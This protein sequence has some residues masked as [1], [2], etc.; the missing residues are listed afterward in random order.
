M[1]TIFNRFQEDNVQDMLDEVARQHRE[2]RINKEGEEWSGGGFLKTD[3]IEINSIKYKGFPL[4]I[5]TE[6]DLHSDFKKAPLIKGKKKFE[7]HPIHEPAYLNGFILKEFWDDYGEE[8]ILFLKQND[9]I[10]ETDPL[11]YDLDIFAKDNNIPIPP[12]GAV[13][14]DK[15]YKPYERLKRHMVTTN[16]WLYNTY[17]T[18]DKEKDLTKFFGKM[19]PFWIFKLFECMY[20]AF[21]IHHINYDWDKYQKEDFWERLNELFKEFFNKIRGISKIDKQLK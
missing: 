18:G 14:M 7:Q 20:V 19:T 8:F 13:Y 11:Y 6:G 15:K 1:T 12:S 16:I 4:F 10:L 2:G 17:L 21:D 3:I 5:T 9:V